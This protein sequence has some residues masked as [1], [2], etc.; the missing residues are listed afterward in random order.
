MQT[1]RALF[2]AARFYDV[3]AEVYRGKPWHKVLTTADLPYAKATASQFRE[4]SVR[5]RIDRTI[6]RP[7]RKNK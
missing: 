2:P 1:S 7:S 3:V 5:V 4:A 6:I